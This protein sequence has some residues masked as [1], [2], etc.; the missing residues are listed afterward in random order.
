M[1][2]SI[3]VGQAKE[4]FS[5]LMSRVAYRGERFVIT[6]RG[7]PMAALVSAGDTERLGS[8]AVAPRGLLAA[9]GCLADFEELDQIV[10]EI[11]RKRKVT[12]D[13]AVPSVDE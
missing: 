4:R 12:H 6:R 11:Y 8:A 7:K 3:G 5:E 1:S 13:R 2:T 10:K 9:V